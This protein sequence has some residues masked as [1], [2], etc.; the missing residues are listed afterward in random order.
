MN[1]KSHGT[2]YASAYSQ[3]AGRETWTKTVIERRAW[4]EQSIGQATPKNL[5]DIGCGRGLNT[6]WLASPTCRWYGTDIVSAETLKLEL[7]EYSTFQ[8]G[9]LRNPHWVA[10][11]PLMRQT[12][13]TVVDQGSVL[14]S[15]D[16]ITERQSYIELL[17]QLVEPGGLLI[18]LVVYGTGP[19]MT[20]P[21]G[22]IRALST[23]ESLSAELSE[24][25]QVET[26]ISTYSAGDERNP[27][28]MQELSVL[29]A[30]FRRR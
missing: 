25:E 21:D 28:V 5:L 27:L 19:A 2:F 13:E 10:T 30:T 12:Y 4:V 3:T 22:R 29:H 7:S 14:V 16:D 24:F 1:D 6:L 9:D 11:S 17:N 26:R 18:L 15:L 20:F 23:P 8:Q